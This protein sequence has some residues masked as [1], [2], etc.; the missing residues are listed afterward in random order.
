MKFIHFDGHATLTFRQLDALNDAPKGTS[1]RRF[2]AMVEQL[3]EG[4]DYFHL[5]ADEHAELIASLQRDQLAYPGTPHVVLITEAGYRR[6]R[7]SG[8]QPDQ[9]QG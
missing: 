8:D 4:R 1:F 5:S 2:R 7:Q 6:M 9:A 3:R